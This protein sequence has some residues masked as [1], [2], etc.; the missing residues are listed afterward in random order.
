[1]YG[2][3]AYAEY[4]YAEPA[5]TGSLTGDIQALAAEA[6]IELF[7]VDATALGGTVSRFHAGTNQLKVNVVWQ[8]NTYVAMPI[9]VSGFEFTGKGKLPRPTMRVQNV[10][11]LIGAL[12]DTY[13]D[14]IAAVVTRKRTFVKYLDAINFTSGVNPTADPTATF[15]DD[16]YAINRKSSHTKS[17]IE[18]ELTSSFDIHGVQ[19]PRRQIIQHTCL[20]VYRGAECSYV[21]GPVATVDDVATADALLDVCGKRIAS[22]KIRFGAHGVLPFG[23]FPGTGVVNG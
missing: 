19:L 9:E 13:D 11:G 16:V 4:G 17:V 21:G 8:G 10:D 14:L 2:Q 12:V 20:W 23:G 7:V 22:C 18:F 6:L 1:M 3:A 5:I 15:P